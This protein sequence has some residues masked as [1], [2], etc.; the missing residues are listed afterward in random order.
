MYIWGSM[1]LGISECRCSDPPWTPV[2]TVLL[3]SWRHGPLLIHWCQTGRTRRTAKS[4]HTHTS[5]HNTRLQHTLLHEG[6]FSAAHTP[7]T[8]Y[9]VRASLQQTAASASDCQLNQI[10]SAL[11]W[12]WRMEEK[13]KE[14]GKK[15]KMWREWRGVG[16]WIRNESQRTRCVKEWSAKWSEERKRA[17][18]LTVTVKEREKERK[19]GGNKGREAGRAALQ[20]G[21]IQSEEVRPTRSRGLLFT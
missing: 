3:P 17:E 9:G 1:I 8:Q 4:S 14:R 11:P 15:K 21:R 7:W 16:Q 13:K 20:R 18:D 19:S 10:G 12:W 2:F 5:S 6:S